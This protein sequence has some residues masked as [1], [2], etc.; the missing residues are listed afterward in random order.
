M[1]AVI[2]RTIRSSVT[3]EGTET[4][5]IGAG[6][7]VLLGV[8][9]DDDEKDVVYTADKILNL[10]IFE[11]EEG[12]MNQ[13]L[14]QKGGEMLV[15]SQFTLYGD[16]R[17]GRR[18]SFTAAAPPDSANRLYEEFVQY[19]EKQGVRVATG[20]F[21]TEMV[22]SLDNHGPVTILLDSKKEF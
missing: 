2:Q 15:V 14:L 16:V 10:R 7:T 18:P 13:S 17:H 22:V 8:G 19:V 9:R 20:V 1:R 5:R 6:L 4:G 21:Q 12:K 11:D 3:S